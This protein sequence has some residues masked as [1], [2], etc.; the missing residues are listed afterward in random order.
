MAEP[1]V[2]T[3]CAVRQQNLE[4]HQLSVSKKGDVK[5]SVTV[6]ERDLPLVYGL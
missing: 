5:D 2:V 6:L 4:R 1:P 3:A